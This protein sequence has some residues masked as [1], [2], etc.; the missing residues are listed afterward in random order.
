MSL[1]SRI[2]RS[3][4]A[5]R[6]G[7]YGIPFDKT[8]SDQAPFNVTHA[9][10]GD[11]F[12]VYIYLVCQQLCIQAAEL[13]ASQYQYIM[14]AGMSIVQ[15]NSHRCDTLQSSTSQTEWNITRVSAH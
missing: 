7:V 4:Y 11:I 9:V 6:H 13:N 8:M 14:I 1:R 3:D 12:L 5:S 15:P 10:S 2:P